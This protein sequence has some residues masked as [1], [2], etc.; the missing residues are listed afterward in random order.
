MQLASTLEGDP[1][2][3]M[4][5]LH[6]HVNQK[7]DY[8]KMISGLLI[9]FHGVISLPDTLSCDNLCYHMMLLLG[10]I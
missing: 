8:D 3:W 6:L 10:V 1:L 7:S 5:P 2:I 4:M 9:L